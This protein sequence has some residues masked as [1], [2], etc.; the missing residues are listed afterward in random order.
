MVH[1]SALQLHNVLI[2]HLTAILPS[3]LLCQ[4]AYLSARLAREVG[5]GAGGKIPG[6]KIPGA[7]TG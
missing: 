3:V 7:Q 6:A 1:L 2:N 5:G 4:M